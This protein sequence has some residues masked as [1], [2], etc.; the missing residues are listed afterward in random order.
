M[1]DARFYGFLI[2]RS[3]LDLP[4]NHLLAFVRNHCELLWDGRFRRRAR[5]VLDD[6][7]HRDFRESRAPLLPIR[8]SR[9]ADS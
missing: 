5:N 3:L 9:P 2:L 7:V 8:A 1:T 6:L 4:R